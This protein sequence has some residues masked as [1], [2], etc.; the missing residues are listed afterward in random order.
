MTKLL[1]HF[2]KLFLDLGDGI[3]AFK[4]YKSGK[5]K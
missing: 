1:N 5:V 3:H 2:K 4:S